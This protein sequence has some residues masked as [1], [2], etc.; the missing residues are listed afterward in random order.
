M[1]VL[2][3]KVEN[4]NAPRPDGL[5]PIHVAAQEG[6]TE[7]I[8]FLAPKVEKPNAPK[9]HTMSEPYIKKNIPVRF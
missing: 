4:P 3:S 2:S 6:H 7:V 5:T 9:A 8:K 1:K